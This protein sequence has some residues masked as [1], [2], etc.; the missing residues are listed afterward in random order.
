MFQFEPWSWSSGAALAA[1]LALAPCSAQAL[2]LIGHDLSQP[3]VPYAWT[4]V[5]A[6]DIKWTDSYDIRKAVGV[7]LASGASY[8]FDSFTAMLAMVTSDGDEYLKTEQVHAAIYRDAGGQLGTLLADLGTLDLT[9]LQPI[10]SPFAAQAITW[11]AAAPVLLQGGGT[12]WF[13]LNDASQ[14]SEFGIPLA[15]WSIMV[16]GAQT[17]PTGVQTLAGYRLSGD[18]GTNWNPSAFY[19]AMQIEVTAV[20]EPGSWALLL[21]GLGLGGVMARPRLQAKR[22]PVARRGQPG[23]VDQ[24]RAGSSA[25]AGLGAVAAGRLPLCA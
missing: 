22:W 4:A 11:I 17:V 10:Q 13:A 23:K 21:V 2:T 18:G 9:P 20:P 5:P 14:Y 7:T 8:R 12:Y 16:S 19:N 15:H 25:P 24:M 1:S 6:T 3:V